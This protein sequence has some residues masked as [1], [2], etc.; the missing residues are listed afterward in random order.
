MGRRVG[1]AALLL[2]TSC[3]SSVT[4]STV[5]VQVQPP[6]VSRADFSGVIE[7]APFASQFLEI[8]EPLMPVDDY[9]LFA[10]SNAALTRVFESRQ[11]AIDSGKDV[12]DFDQ[13]LLD[14][15]MLS[16]AYTFDQ[17]ASGN[18]LVLRTKSGI[19]LRILI[20]KSDGATYLLLPGGGRARI[21]AVDLGTKKGITHIIDRVIHEPSS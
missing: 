19:E 11:A 1:V 6:E 15:H 7:R 2:A 10:P 14:D 18:R 13:A 17:L 20:T 12:G 5:V 8:V 4:E 21:Q 9:T 3:S 16:S